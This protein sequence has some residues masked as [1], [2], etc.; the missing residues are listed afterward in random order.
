MRA[1][2]PTILVISL[3]RAAERR[4]FMASQ[5]L[6]L[7]LNFEFVDAYD[8]LDISDTELELINRERTYF[9]ALTKGEVACARSHA[10]ACERLA[11]DVRNQY[12]LIMED[13]VI[14]GSALSSVLEDLQEAKPSAVVLLYMPVYQK[15]SL[16]V[17]RKLRTGHHIVD[18]DELSHVFGAQAYFLS[19]ESARQLADAIVPV[20]TIAD[21]WKKYVNDKVVSLAAVFPFPALHAEFLSAVNEKKLSQSIR[22]RVKNFLY[23]RRVFPF[24]QMFLHWRRCNAESRQRKNITFMGRR[25]LKTF[26]L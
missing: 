5:F 2:M 18:V 7:K 23:A 14:A 11:L 1:E 21:D 4:Q 22:G 8:A 9:K 17:R 19:K 12:G 26:K 13:D 10:K 15:I 24:Y 3:A 6:R 16:L 25:A 20:R